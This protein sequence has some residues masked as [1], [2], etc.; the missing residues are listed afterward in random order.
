MS[1]RDIWNLVVVNAGA[2]LGMTKL[3][4]P[5]MQKKRNGAIITIGSMSS[6]RPIPLMSV[7]SASKVF[8]L[9]ILMK[10]PLKFHVCAAETPV[11]TEAVD[12]FLLST[13]HCARKTHYAT[14]YANALIFE[15]CVQHLINQLHQ[16]MY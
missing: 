10:L 14:F 3:V 12:V 4:L 11:F 6:F 13:F 5:S 1:E 8:S 2:C 9:L 15:L 16:F 7:Y